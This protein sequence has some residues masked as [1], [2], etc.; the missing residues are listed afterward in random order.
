[1]LRSTR[2]AMA[3]FRVRSSRSDRGLGVIR[4]AALRA[5]RVIGAPGIVVAFITSP[6]SGVWTVLRS[7]E[8][9][10]RLPGALTGPFGRGA[11]PFEASQRIGDEVRGLGHAEARR[12]QH[13]VVMVRVRGVLFE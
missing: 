12:V 11:T 7:G 3:S 9:R 4:S 5:R 8:R 1:M 13:E 6:P 10:A 2:K